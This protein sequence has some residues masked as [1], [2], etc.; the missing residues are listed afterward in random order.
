[1]K[2]DLEQI[3][4]LLPAI[5]RVR[6]HELKEGEESPPLRALL[7]IIAEE[8]EFLEDNVDQLYDD[9]FIETCA[10]WVVPYIGELVGSKP[11]IPVK[12]SGFSSRTEVANT[13]AYRR[14][15]GTLSIIE[16]LARDITHWDANVVE[17]FKLLATTQYLNHLR[18]ENLVVP[19]LNNWEQLEYINTPFD[20]IP[21]TAD[22]RNINI[23]RGKYNIPNIGIFLW[24]ISASS[25]EKSPAFHI[26]GQRYSFH[27][28]GVDLQLYNFP[29]AESSLTQLAGPQNMPVPFRRRLLK[30]HINNHYGTGKDIFIQ[31]GPDRDILAEEICI[32][33]LSNWEDHSV[34][35]PDDIVVVDPLLGRIQ[36]G[37]DFSAELGSAEIHVWYNYGSQNLFGGGEYFRKESFSEIKQIITISKDTGVGDFENIQ[38]AINQAQT[39]STNAVIEILDNETY[40]ETLSI[41]L[42]PGQSLE[43][44]AVQGKQ[45]V[46]MLNGE[47]TITGDELADL[48][49]NGLLIDAGN[50]VVQS[51]SKLEKITIIHCTI[52][53]AI[54]ENRI[55]LQSPTLLQIQY[56]V[57]AGIETVADCVLTIEN[58]VVDVIDQ[59]EKAIT[60]AENELAK[61]T[62]LNSTILGLIEVKEVGLIEN[63]ILV[64]AINV[65]FLQ[66]GCVRFSYLP[67][68]SVT[69]GKY[70]CYP[71]ETS[72]ESVLAPYFKSTTYGNAAYFQN[73]QLADKIF[74]EGADDGSELGAYHNLFQPQKESNLKT[75]LSE[76]LRFGMEAGI[77]YAS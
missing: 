67:S 40:N 54:A 62:I 28:L 12:S 26:G 44:R 15:K 20:T 60:G 58:S 31:I 39:S 52:R 41:D 61:L 59:N 76:Y 4:S 69:P 22:V 9:Y 33:D 30:E 2:F 50:L 77:F 10:E 23:K 11:L 1:M 66:S 70:N 45:P 75:R 18:P 57:I 25:R 48:T 6:D 35:P 13:I 3:Y 56:S 64:S 5:Y 17:Y 42:G 53:P 37:E 38:E 47:I 27:P 19:H 71:G 36:F 74:L 7:A 46:L 21:R 65:V 55:I 63:S 73:H 72:N 49:L 32:G 34:I 8:V 29:K 14:R 16:Q 51:T 24:R 68:G 43:L